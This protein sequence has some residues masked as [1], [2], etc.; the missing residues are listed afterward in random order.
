M[1]FSCCSSNRSKD[2]L[3]K[4]KEKNRDD[5][6]EVIQ[7]LKT[8]E[9]ECSFLLCCKTG[10]RPLTKQAT[11]HNNI[12]YF[13]SNEC[14][15]EWLKEYNVKNTAVSPSTLDSPEYIKKC[16]QHLISHIPLLNI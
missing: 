9:I 12:Y 11:I 10:I 4:K 14:W 8:I 7:N 5:L 13:C 6:L 15:G 3:I 2:K 16:S 1:D